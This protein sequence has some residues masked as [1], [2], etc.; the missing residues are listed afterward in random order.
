MKARILQPPSGD[1][2]VYTGMG[3]D[4]QFGEVVECEWFCDKK[5]GIKVKGSEFLRLGGS[6][7]AFLHP[8]KDYIW[9]TFE[10]VT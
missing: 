6:P 8:D 4:F 3:E 5:N 1:A 2:G 7:E 10:V 9:G